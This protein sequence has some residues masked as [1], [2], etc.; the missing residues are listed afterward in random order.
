MYF[1]EELF[2]F[3]P[4]VYTFIYI[5]CFTFVNL[6]LFINKNTLNFDSTFD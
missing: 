1:I 3:V 4:F 6:I 5:Y 2:E